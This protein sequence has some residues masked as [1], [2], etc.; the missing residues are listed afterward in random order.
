M[1]RRTQR[2]AGDVMSWALGVTA[3]LVLG[4][5]LLIATPQLM[6]APR[7]KPRRPGRPQRPCPKRP[8]SQ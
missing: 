6:K 1:N 2:E 3:G 5:T 4:V 7:P 8:P